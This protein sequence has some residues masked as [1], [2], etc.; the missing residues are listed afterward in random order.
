ML[1]DPAWQHGQGLA[2][3]IR[4][5]VL[6]SGVYDLEP[7]RLSARNTYLHL[8]ESDV[9]ALS[10]HRHLPAM[11]PPTTLFWGDGELTEFKRQSEAFAAALNA[12]GGAVTTHV[13]AGSNHF[14]VYDLFGDPKSAVVDA[15][16]RQAAGLPL[17]E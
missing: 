17:G 2:D 12:A 14:D 4:G 13:I 5:F 3:P 9:L 16:R 1:L 6:A 7:V 11:P 10:P 15:V 8:T